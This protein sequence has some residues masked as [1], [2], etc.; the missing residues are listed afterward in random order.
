MIAETIRAAAGGDGRLLVIEG[1]AG[2]GK[3]ALIAE[4]RLAARGAGLRVLGA[5]G[6]ELEQDFAFGVVRQLFEPALASAGAEDH[7][8]WLAGAAS[9]ASPLFDPSGAAFTVGDPGF[10][11]RHGLYWLAAN[12]S[13]AGEGGLVILVDD[14]HWAD[15]ASVEFLGFLARRLEELPIALIAAGRPRRDA[16]GGLAID[17]AAHVLR[18]AP[19]TEAE[20]AT[21]VASV[22]P[23]NPDRSFCEAC[24]SATGGVP[25][26]LRELLRDVAIERIAPLAEHARRVAVLSPRNV[27]T[28]VALRLARMPTAASS[29]AQAVAVLGDGVAVGV[30][31][32][33]AG[34]DDDEV[35]PAAQLLVEADVLAAEEQLRFV[36]PIVRA[37]IYDGMPA[38]ERPRAHARAAVLLQA[39]GASD[40]AIAV[41]LRL[42]APT[43]QPWA[44]AVLRAAAQRAQSLG[45]PA[46][47]AG[48]LRAALA[49]VGVGPD[50]IV[51]LLELA[52]AQWDAGDM[53][54]VDHLVEAAGL[55]QSPAQRAQIAVERA[56][57]LR[58]L[59]RGL[60]AL[61]VV[62]AAE[63]ELGARD[64]E[65]S[66]RLEL[67]RLGA[68]TMS[69][70][71]LRQLTPLSARLPAP[72]GPPEN[73]YARF[74][75]GLLALDQAQCGTSAERVVDLAHR[76]I[77]ARPSSLPPTQ[78]SSQA[79]A[80]A[81]IAL[82]LADRYE[83]AVALTDGLVELTERLGVIAAAASLIAQ[84][85][86]IHHRRGALRDAE[87]DAVR[88]LELGS[89]VRAAVA[90]HT[91][92]G[93]ILSLVAVEQ[94]V[95]PD[96]ELMAAATATESTATR[97]LS[98]SRAEHLLAQG[99][100]SAAVLE[101]FA[102]GEFERQLG[103]EGPAQYPWRSQAAL[104]LEQLGHRDRARALAVEELKLARAYGAPRP[105]GIS[106]RAS[107]RLA[108]A[109]GRIGLLQEAVEVLASSG[110]DLEH[111][112]GLIELGRALRVSGRRAASRDQLMR[113][114]ELANQCGSTRLADHAWQELLATGA[115]P[116]RKELRGVASLTPSER[117][118]AELAAAG[119]T[120]REIAQALFVTAKTV[121]THLGHAYT[122]LGI[123]SR[124]DLDA[125]LR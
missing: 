28:A 98:Y 49:E 79:I 61:E 47:A 113:G 68:A 38:P 122:K 107:G 117:R 67:E 2:I 11:R 88:A 31:A 25:F 20:V 96:P 34:I 66:E 43:G 12:M 30:A 1:P 4:A 99:Q 65:L 120:N 123:S 18:P 92:A 45:A 27:T 36:H 56:R 109:Q 73:D 14:V 93:G 105:I 24:R 110:A 59:G 91:R 87:A 125:A 23:G 19:L 118:I 115:R 10:Q 104:A 51:V 3:T 84:R 55:A 124:L 81:A 74:R 26:L 95:D 119:G 33:L 94:G 63:A 86:Q 46:V 111:A 76:A 97:S 37:A 44:S 58:F 39:R 15:T 29:L 64:P 102:I 77:G 41:Q 90:L 21:L 16:F 13:T 17:P 48:H 114:H 70:S 101:L 103:W 69:T 112:R 72:D 57:M 100:L 80:M 5:R 8:A 106:L 108:E 71:V 53:D 50:R 54:A 6:S 89:E 85:A 121:E 42:A 82:S 7:E 62:E 83:E 78:L 75:L 52:Q 40:E 22:L 60:E 9:L 32:E 35:R 116:R